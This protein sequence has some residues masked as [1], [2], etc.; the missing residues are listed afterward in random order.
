MSRIHERARG[1]RDGYRVIITALHVQ[2]LQVE[3][4]S[5]CDAFN[6]TAYEIGP[7]LTKS[8]GI[9]RQK[10][11]E[12]NTGTPK[13]CELYPSFCLCYDAGKAYIADLNRIMET[14]ERHSASSSRAPDWHIGYLEGISDG[15]DL[16]ERRAWKMTYQPVHELLMSFANDLTQ[17]YKELTN[18]EAFFW[19]YNRVR[20]DKLDSAPRWRAVLK[21][22]SEKQG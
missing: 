16:I 5:S 17:R 10:L 18:S 14:A 13:R 7:L 9:I 8:F 2:A 3:Q 20:L 15:I 21:G 4:A 6:S 11:D 22:A 1:Y 12:A 19:F